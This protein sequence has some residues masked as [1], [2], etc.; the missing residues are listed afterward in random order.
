MKVLSWNCRGVGNPRTVR[1]ISDLVR[2]I[3][4]QVVGLIETKAELKRIEVLKRKLGFKNGIA[5]DRSGLGGGLALLWREAVQVVLKSYSR[6]HI[7]VWVGDDDGFRMTLF[8]GNPETGRRDE[9]WDLLRSLK[10]GEHQP[11]LVLGDF[12]EILFSWEYMGR[13]LRGEWQMRRFRQAV[14]DCELSDLGFQGAKFTFTNRRTGEEEMRARLDRALANKEWKLNYPGAI[15]Q[16]LTTFSSDHLPLVVDAEGDMRRRKCKLFRFEAMW[17]R[18]ENFTGVLQRLWSGGSTNVMHKLQ[19]VREGLK[20]WNVK[21]YGRVDKKVRELKSQLDV[22]RAQ[23]RTVALAEEETKVCGRLDEWLRREELLWKQRS[24]AD[25]LKEGDLNTKYFHA[26]ASQRMQVNRIRRLAASTGEWVTDEGDILN[27]VTE[28][29]QSLFSNNSD[30]AG[31]RWEEELSVVPMKLQEDDVIFLS[32][33]FQ[34]GEVRTALFQMNPA[35]A[36]GLDGFGPIFYQKNWELVGEDLTSQCLDILNGDGEVDHLNKTLITLIPKCKDP[37]GVANFRPISLCNVIIKIVTK[38]LANRL[39]QVLHKVIAETQSA[40]VPGRLITDNIL[41]AHEIFHYMKTRTG[42]SNIFGALK[43]DMSKAYDRVDWVFLEQMQLRLGFPHSWVQKVMKCV[44]TVTYYIRVNDTVSR[45]V[46]PERGIR[47][48]DPLSP[49]LFVIC[50]EWLACVLAKGKVDGRVVGVKI[51]RDAPNVSHLFFADDC[52]LFFKAT[53][54]H[55]RFVKQCLQRF[56]LLSGQQLNYEKS[57]MFFGKNVEATYAELLCNYLGV[58]RGQ[59]LS[60][61]L[62]MPILFNKNKS[63]VFRELE[64]KSW[65]RVHGWKEQWLSSAGKEILLKSILQALPVFVMSCF[66]LPSEV[67]KK[68]ASILFT[69]WWGKGDGRKHI[70]WVRR[71]VLT[72][73]KEDGG[74]GF[75]C[76]E[77][78]NE[79][80]LFKQLCRLQYQQDSLVSKALRAKYF[81]ISGLVEARLGCRPSYAW[82]CLWQIKEKLCSFG[83]LQQV[84]RQGMES[85]VTVR[86]VYDVLLSNKRRQEGNVVGESSNQEAKRAFWRKVWRVKVQSKI[87]IFMWRVFHNALP[88]AD[89]LVRRGCQTELMCKVCGRAADSICHV[90]LNCDWAVAMW[91]DVLRGKQLWLSGWR[92]PADWMWETVRSFSLKDLPAVFSAAYAIWFNRNSVWH[93][94]GC[95]EVRWSA[96]KVRMLAQELRGRHFTFCTL[97]S[98]PGNCWMPP[99]EGQV[100]INVDAAWSSVSR[101]AGAACLGRDAARRVLFVWADFKENVPSALAAEVWALNMTMRMSEKLKLR[102][103]I[104]ETDNVSVMDMVL[105]GCQGKAENEMVLR[106]ALDCQVILG[107]NLRWRVDH[108]LREGNRVAD[109]LAKKAKETFWSW[110]LSTAIPYCLSA[111]I[112]EE[113]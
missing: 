87:K 63:A 72:A 43:L 104:F 35:K 59:I 25:W 77:L 3:G 82:R 30:T 95:L 78:L 52:V 56:E 33:P 1:A 18:H 16:H 84:L 39:K 106:D 61:Y 75:K 109:W 10:Q 36:P 9:S 85:Q 11:W 51:C 7:D 4:P 60:K 5:V 19:S 28:Y 98:E 24:R 89:N 80:L 91:Q 42:M 8:Y 73:K 26:K 40:F 97:R 49:Y 66:R 54:Q 81:G 64:E 17:Q 50:M 107:R 110:T 100:K 23:P 74:M 12:N 47:Q 38:C 22:L 31:F 101:R 111:V 37:V 2:S 94:K 15:V 41:M 46:V 76:L 69:Y 86:E 103:A 108:V 27:V 113:E 6:N 34:P 93:G 112:Q 58:K 65:K 21:E 67:C 29:F 90:L 99:E 71:S 62:G 13:R 44:T 48:G 68:L 45:G 55:L 96:A 79:A 83:V 92:D 53:F 14:D 88:T 105:L 70:C 32:T 57:E 102:R 20:E